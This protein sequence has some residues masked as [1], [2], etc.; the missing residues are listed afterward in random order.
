MSLI[1]KETK[2]LRFFRESNI[3]KKTY[4]VSIVNVS[5]NRTIGVIQWY[6]PWRQYCFYPLRNTIWNKDCLDSV[7]EVI[8]SLMEERKPKKDATINK[9]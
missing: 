7:N 9:M 4:Y 1:I 2:Y 3:H 6:S 5:S 8:T